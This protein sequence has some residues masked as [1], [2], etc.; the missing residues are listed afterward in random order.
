MESCSDFAFTVANGSRRAFGAYAAV[1]ALFLCALL[2][3]GTVLVL[4]A[5]LLVVDLWPLRRVRDARTLVAAAIEKGPLLALSV[6]FARVAVWGQQ[7]IPGLMASWTE[8]TLGERV[9]QAFFGLVFYVR[10]TILPDGLAPIYE[11]PDAL[12]L[13]DPRYYLSIAAVAA[14][15]AILFFWRRRAP[16]LLAAGAA[17][18]IA[19]AP[20]LGF[21]QAGP[22]IAADRYTYLACLPFALLAG[23]AVVRWRG[24]AAKAA[25]VAVLA[26]LAVLTGL[27]FAQTRVWR[28]SAALWEHAIALD[29]DAVLNNLNLG[30]V[31]A[32]QA[33]R[34]ADRSAQAALLDESQRLFEHGL[35][36][37]EDPLLLAG[38]ALVHQHRWEL[39]P[40]N[41]SAEA[42]LSLEFA[43]R[44]LE[45]AKQRNLE[46]PD[47]H[48]NLG[49]ALG[50]AQHPN[51]ALAEFQTYVRERPSSYLGHYL[52]GFAL[53]QASRFSESV[54]ELGQAVDLEPGSVNGWG[55]LGIAQEKLGEKDLAIQAYQRVLALAPG[56]PTAKQHLFLLQS[57][58]SVDVV[59]N[60]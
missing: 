18:A 59:P 41:R 43:R 19:V 7:W 55:N 11:L 31:R 8:H 23:A 14:G 35:R 45:V 24:H 30:H 13:A 58:M 6:V 9:L 33:E 2:S 36:I 52:L 4:P 49:S 34:T 1:I 15:T 60:K 38:I 48:L 5:V 47:Y 51:D 40:K 27:T 54:R 22:Q 12:R 17:Y 57:R 10:K 46:T 32:R 37:R 44:A 26:V 3:K 42:E 16:A 28:S 56:H 50:N 39:D 21:S 25:A 20:V 53:L 29:P